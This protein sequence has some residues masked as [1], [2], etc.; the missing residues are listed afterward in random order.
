MQH[1]LFKGTFMKTGIIVAMQN[2]FNLIAQNLTDKKEHS[3]KHILF[4][5][6]KLNGENVVLMKSGIGKTNSTIATIEM[7]NKFQPTRIINTGIAGGLDKSL[8]VMDV[9]IAQQTTYH[10]VWCGE[11]LYGQIQGLPARFI[12]NKTLLLASQRIKTDLKIHFGLTVSGDKF[13]TKLEELQNMKQQFPDALA[14]DMESN[15]I[16]QTCYLYNVPFLSVR[17]ISDTPGIT[18]HSEQYQNFWSLAP[19][20]SFN[21]LEQL[22]QVKEEERLWD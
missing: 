15:S 16:A 7:I 9:V 4:I 8:N 11:G 17:L 18:N 3:L 2:E 14:V 20:K 13:I 5:E 12:G 1:R 10:D 22:I 6:G 21:I 19:E